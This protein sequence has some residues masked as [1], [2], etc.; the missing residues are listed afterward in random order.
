MSQELILNWLN[1]LSETVKERDLERHMALVSKKVQVYGLP[2]EKIVDYRG[3]LRRRKSE[4]NRKIL[5]GIEYTDLNIKTITL[6][7]LGFNIVETMHAH[8]GKRIIIQK[9]IMLELE[10]NDKWRVVEETI[11]DWSRE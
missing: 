4:F 11:K 7:R 1:E 9:E 8:N 3:W 10:D 2:S 6:R 5:I